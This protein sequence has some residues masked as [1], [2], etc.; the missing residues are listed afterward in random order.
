MCSSAW[1]ETSVCM[2]GGFET[3]VWDTSGPLSG[4]GVVAKVQSAQWETAGL[5]AVHPSSRPRPYDGS[6]W[7]KTSSLKA[8]FVLIQK[9]GHY[10]LTPMPVETGVKFIQALSLW[11]LG[12]YTS[13]SCLIPNRRFGPQLVQVNLSFLT[14]CVYFAI[15]QYKC[16]KFSSGPPW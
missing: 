2:C 13:M 5:T 7:W 14:T 4:R 1:W 8:M 6:E 9:S 3:S 12:N 16:I 15:I 11:Q 10:R